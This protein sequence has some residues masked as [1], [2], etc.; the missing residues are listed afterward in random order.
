V[1]MPRLQYERWAGG[2][3]PRRTVERAQPRVRLPRF[4]S[5][6]VSLFAG[7]HA[8][9]W[10]CRRAH[11]AAIARAYPGGDEMDRI[12]HN[13]AGEQALQVRP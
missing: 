3:E 7:A 9:C 12:L 4:A 6:C 11:R 13:Y 1:D 10:S 5:A 2:I 8:A